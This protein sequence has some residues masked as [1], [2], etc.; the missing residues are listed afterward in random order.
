[1]KH[2]KKIIGATAGAVMAAAAALVAPWE[3]F[4]GKTYRDIVGVPT[5]CYGETDKAAVEEGRKRTFTQAECLKMLQDRLPEYDV[6]FKR[7]ITREIPS[8]VHIAMVSAAYN[9]GV[10]G[11]C[12]STMVRRI[13]VG[14][15]RGACD[16]LLGWNRA[17]GRVVKGLDNRRKA[18]RRVCLE[19]L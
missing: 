11:M 3:G 6:G 19:G 18:E 16:A 5:V 8:S 7:C 10:G 17:G 13:N 15:F 1:M 9:I 2:K 12:K 4:Y 14:D